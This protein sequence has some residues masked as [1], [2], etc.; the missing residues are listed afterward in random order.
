MTM[1][2]VDKIIEDFCS[3]LA[4]VKDSDFAAINLAYWAS[5]FTDTATALRALGAEQRIPELDRLLRAALR[6]RFGGGRA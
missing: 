1:S 3:D 2:A 4:D 6:H 5:L